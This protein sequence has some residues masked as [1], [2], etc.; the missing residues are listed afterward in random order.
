MNLRSRTGSEER[1]SRLARTG[2]G[3]KTTD[4]LST[5]STTSTGSESEQII[6]NAKSL[7]GEKCGHSFRLLL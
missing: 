2:I 3:V 6:I 5:D 7:Q 1:T 4:S